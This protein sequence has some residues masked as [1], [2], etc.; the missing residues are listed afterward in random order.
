MAAGMA[1]VVAACAGTNDLDPAAAAVYIDR[2]DPPA[3]TDTALL[4]RLS[5]AL[6]RCPVPLAAL[7]SSA[8]ITLDGTPRLAMRL[9]AGFRRVTSA[10]LPTPTMQRLDGPDG[11]RI[12]VE[13]DAN[14]YVAFGPA[15]SQV[16]EAVRFGC[17]QAAQGSR[18]PAQLQ[19]FVRRDPVI[20][21][22]REIV[23]AI[24]NVPTVVVAGEA[25]SI[26]V[27]ARTPE[28]RAA[29]VTLAVR[30]RAVP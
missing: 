23:A 29:L 19:S 21:S 10:R 12:L 4:R 30:V 13:R 28:Q 27:Y 11:A 15:Y 8:T 17:W 22:P 9:P 14:R 20:A 6:P 24:A 25:V 16:T 3:T 26:A 1:S 18:V 5:F 2:I 7:D